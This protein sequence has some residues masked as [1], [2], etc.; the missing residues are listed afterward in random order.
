MNYSRVCDIKAVNV[1]PLTDKNYPTWKLQIKMTL[2]KE[3]LFNIV[4]GT[5]L[6]PTRGNELNKFNQRKLVS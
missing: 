1:I 5:E 4:N 3:G 6:S 2:M